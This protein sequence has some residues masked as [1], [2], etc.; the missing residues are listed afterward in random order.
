MQA[1]SILLTV[2][3]WVIDCRLQRGTLRPRNSASYPRAFEGV[4]RYKGVNFRVDTI[5][6]LELQSL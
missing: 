5:E 6:V 1:G 3:S 4:R 2:L